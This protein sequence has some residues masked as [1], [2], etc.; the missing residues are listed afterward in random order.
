MQAPFS[1]Q[2]FMDQEQSNMNHIISDTAFSQPIKGLGTTYNPTGSSPGAYL[3]T[4]ELIISNALAVLTIVGGITF[5]VY[6]LLGGVNW[7]TAGGKQDKIET[8]KGMMTNGAIGLIIILVSYALVW[9]I[10]KVLGLDI[11]NPATVLQKTIK[12]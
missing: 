6:F 2:L 1:N 11:L 9:I 5:V 8:A 12:F 7:I 3:T 4:F 10:G